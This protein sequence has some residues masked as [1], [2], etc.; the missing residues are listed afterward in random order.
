MATETKPNPRA[1]M[2]RLE[3]PQFEKVFDPTAADLF[4]RQVEH[5]RKQLQTLVDHPAS[6]A[7]KERAH[8]AFMAYTGA[9]VLVKEVADLRR[10]MAEEATP[11]PGVR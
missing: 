4:F 11:A 10:K 9:L 5:T 3:F 8:A 1:A 6:A 7:E 2:P